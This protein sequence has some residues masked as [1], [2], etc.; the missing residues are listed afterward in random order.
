MGSYSSLQEMQLRY[1][2][3]SSAAG[4]APHTT[5]CFPG[6]P[7]ASVPW[8]TKQLGWLRMKKQGKSLQDK[9]WN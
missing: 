1:E 3:S 5:L 8:D 7:R 2:I 4:K 9:M 6:H